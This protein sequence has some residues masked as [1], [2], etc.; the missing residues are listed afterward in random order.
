MLLGKA[1]RIA[2]QLLD[3]LNP[4]V[5]QIAIVGSIRRQKPEV[6]DIDI[7]AIPN[8]DKLMKAGYFD[9]RQLV[10]NPAD[11]PRNLTTQF[12]LPNGLKIS[13]FKYHAVQVDI[14]W[15]TP[16]TWATLLLIRTGSKEHNIRLCQLAQRH[17]LHL[18]ASGDGLF[19]NGTRVSW[20]SEEKLFASLGLQ[21]IKPKD[22][23]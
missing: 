15:A 22:R 7:V 6:H 8:E 14:Y 5:D 1:T 21:Y 2:C 18:H 3:E 13:T 19:R 16:E 20:E 10:A 23:H 12:P 9:Q 11:S 17:G 4:Y